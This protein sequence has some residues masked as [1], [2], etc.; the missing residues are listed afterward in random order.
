MD[1]FPAGIRTPADGSVARASAQISAITFVARLAGFARWVMLG[2]AVGTT[3]L[4]NVYQTAN[5]IPNVIF[6]LV[7][8]GLL[9]SVLVPTFVRERE[10]GGGRVSEIASTLANALLFVT[11]PLVLLGIV[12]ARPL[13]ALLLVGV[14]DPVIKAQQVELGAWFLRFF[15]PQVPLYLLGIVMQG[16]LHAHRRFVLPALGPLLSSLTVI[17]TYIV[18]RSMS[19][20]VTL[21]TVSRAQLWVL[22]GGTTLGVLVLTFCQ[23]PSVLR[24]GVRWRPVLAWRDPV[25]RTALRAGGWGAGFLGVTQLMLV[26]AVILANRVEGGVVAFQIANAFFELPNAI[27]GLPV[28]VALFPALSGAFVAH[29]ENRFAQLLSHGWRLVLFGAIP[30]SVGLYLLAPVAADVLLGWAPEVRPQLVAATL[31]GLAIA[32]PPWLVI[33]TLV[34]ALYARGATARPF[35]LNAAAFAVL[36]AAG[37]GGTAVSGAEGADALRL[38][39]SSVGA[40]WWVGAFVGVF[41]LSRL[42]RGW[43]LAEAGRVVAGNLFRGAMV[44]AATWSMLH[45]LRDAPPPVRLSGAVAAGAVVVGVAALGSRQ[46]RSSLAFLGARDQTLEPR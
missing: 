22:A 40:G 35:A 21:D 13:M 31:Q 29:D 12:L 41:L 33:G 37:V 10:A 43:N 7:A 4:G 28:A 11:I 1:P 9:S 15:L 44:G 6:E 30:A 36:L 2:Y 8:G 38:L 20:G 23:L 24:I 26:V 39:G 16:I 46:L 19:E 27:I 32:V 17:A 25:V 34:R 3:Y 14:D 45:L 18:F 5:L 42:A